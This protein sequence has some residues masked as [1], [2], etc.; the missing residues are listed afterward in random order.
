[1]SGFS[2]AMS[3][4]GLIA[5]GALALLFAALAAVQ[6]IGIAAGGSEG[7]SRLGG[8]LGTLFAALVCTAVFMRIL[9]RLRAG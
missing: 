8:L 6:L 5:I 9:R 3:I 2:R 1:M 4:L 7:G